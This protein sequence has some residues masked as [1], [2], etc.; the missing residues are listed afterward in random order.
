MIAG[1]RGAGGRQLT[2]TSLDSWGTGAVKACPVAG[3][4]ASGPAGLG[5]TDVPGQAL[6]AAGAAPARLTHTAEPAGRIVAHTM[7]ARLVGTGVAQGEAERRQ[8]ARRAEAAEAVFRVHAGASLAARAGRAFIDLHVAKG[9]CE[10]RLA[11]TVIAVEAIATDPEGARITGTVI[12]VDLAVHTSGTRRTAAEVLVHQIEAFAPVAAR[13]T[14]AFVHLALAACAG[15]TRSASAGEAGNAIH[16]APMVARVRRAIVHV[17]FTQGTLEALGTVTLIAIWLIDALGAIAAWRA[18]TFVHIKLTGGPAEARGTDAA[19]TVDT[20]PAD[21][22]VDARA[23]LALIDVH[24]AVD[25]RETCHADARELADSVQACSLVATGAGETLVDIGLTARAR[26]AAA[27]LAQ[28][29]AL[30]VDAAA[31]VLARVGSDGTLVHVLIARATREARGTGANGPAVHG[32]GVTNGIFMAWIA[33]AGVIQVAEEAGLAHGAG[34]VERSHTVVAG[35]PVETHGRGAVINVLA[36]TLAR[37]AVDT[38]TAVAA[39]GVEAGAPVVAGVGLQ[40]A[41]IHVLRAELACPLRRTL[42]I[43][44]V[45]AV[46]A[47]APIETPVSRA[48]VHIDFTVLSLKPREAGTVVS[49]V[50]TLSTGAPIAAWRWGAGRGR[51]AGTQ[52]PR[53]AR[54]TLAAKG[55]RR[56][57]AG[58]PMAAW[59]AQPAFVHVVPAAAALVARRAGADEATVG[60]HGAARTMGARAAETG[61]WQGAV[62]ASEATG[63]SAGEAGSARHH[64]AL[65]NSPAGTGARVARIFQLAPFPHPAWWAQASRLPGRQ[66]GAKTSICTGASVQ[67]RGSCSPR[68]R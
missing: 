11:D 66:L 29:G 61:V 49:G 62:G 63:A 68:P 65:A 24:L 55:S 5:F 26:V 25:P 52:W 38:H 31:Q 19:E 4:G 35:G 64:R 43:V 28:E 33:D 23:A 21:A 40:L 22:A 30:G 54:G 7:P 18:G 3:A 27:A 32:V 46:H 51:R 8:G 34:A 53:V 45:D 12:Y 6:T 36:A 20:V 14:T 44:G 42:A 13:L 50:T 56:V 58:A 39:Q 41:L 37:P 1:V 17:A 15:V 16:T 2:L 48:V 9:S 60:P 67:A 59:P 47:G 10:A 57:E